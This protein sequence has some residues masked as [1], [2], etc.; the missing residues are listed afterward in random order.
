VTMC[1]K[2]LQRRGII[3][4]AITLVVCAGCGAS[5]STPSC[6]WPMQVRGTASSVQTGLVR[7]YLRAMAHRDTDGLGLLMANVGPNSHITSGDLVYSHD[8]RA[9]TATATFVPNPSDATFVKLTITYR[10]GV[11]ETTGLYNM[12]AFGKVSVWRMAIGS[13]WDQR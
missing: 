13:S 9:G 8:A 3:V 10:D 4:A 7:C 11:V 12:I 5:A 1:K 2:S 6:S